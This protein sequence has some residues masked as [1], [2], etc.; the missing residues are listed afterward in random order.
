LLVVL[1]IIGI[2]AALLLSALSRG[3]GAADS[4][5]CKS[6]LRQLQFA[7]QM[8]TDDHDGRLVA[9]WDF[10]P[11]WD[12]DYRDSYSS[13]NSWVCGSAY[14]TE[15]TDGI[16]QGALWPYSGSDAIYRCPSD[17][18][19]WHPR[20]RLAPRPFNVGL[21]CCLNGGIEDVYGAPRNGPALDPAIVDTLAA[22]QRPSLMF[23]FL[24][25]EAASICS[26]G[27]WEDLDQNQYW[28]MIPGERDRGCG[29][30]VAF[31]DG[32]VDFHK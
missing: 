27:F 17:K 25:E 18:T 21:N 32:H 1:A 31:V 11:R 29:A 14:T 16:R 22:I 10:Y 24:D 13:T 19:R 26:G 5:A 3:K 7:W 28:W 30:N 4:A 15:S 23:S 2:L 8:Y 20:N 12:R 6:N 9:N